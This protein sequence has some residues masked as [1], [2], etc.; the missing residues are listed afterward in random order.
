MRY[1]VPQASDR[2]RFNRAL[3]ELAMGQTEA[4]LA[5]AP[6]TDEPG[7]RQTLATYLSGPHDNTVAATATRIG[8]VL[9]GGVNAAAPTPTVHFAA[10]RPQNAG[11]A[12]DMHA[13]PVKPV[14]VLPPGETP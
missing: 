6:G 9:I 3:V 8:K 5:D 12:G 11:N 4:A 10:D 14:A 2:Y 13:A 7:L 1:R